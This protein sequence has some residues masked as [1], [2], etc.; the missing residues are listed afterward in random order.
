MAFWLMRKV[1]LL[2]QLAIFFKA[3]LAITVP[4]PATL[5]LTGSAL[6]AGAIGAFFKGRRKVSTE[7]AA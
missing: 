7:V 5:I 4:E 1:G 3:D 6:A 2:E